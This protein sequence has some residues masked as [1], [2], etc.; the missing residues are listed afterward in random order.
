M[1][2]GEDGESGNNKAVY[3]NTTGEFIV[4]VFLRPVPGDLIGTTQKSES[5]SSIN[6]VEKTIRYYPRLHG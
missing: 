2:D 4:N 1:L 3:D 5:L 6:T